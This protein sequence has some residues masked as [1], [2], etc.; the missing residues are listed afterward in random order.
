[1]YL[2]AA[3]E[4]ERRAEEHALHSLVGFAG[5]RTQKSNEGVLERGDGIGSSSPSDRRL[6]CDQ[7]CLSAL[8]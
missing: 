1:M 3:R 4:P 5:K 6:E 7:E 2:V 8:D